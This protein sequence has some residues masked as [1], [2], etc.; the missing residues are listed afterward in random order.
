MFGSPVRIEERARRLRGGVVLVTV[1]ALAAVIATYPRMFDDLDRDADA[2]SSLSFA[3]REI[4]GGN[5]IVADQSAVYA[6]RALIPEKA[7]YHVAV[8]PGYRGGNELTRDHVA[9][10]Y[11]Y[12]LMPRR[13]V[14]GG[15]RWVI[16][17]GC[18][19]TDYGPEARVLWRGGEEISIL[20]VAS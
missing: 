19:V 17:Y 8:S 15:A 12:F 16:C 7:T 10:Y 3:D 20:R 1:V 6:A 11:R 13:P 18:D 2:N 9:S 4:A 14:E 5:G